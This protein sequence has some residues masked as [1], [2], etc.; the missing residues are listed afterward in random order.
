MAYSDFTSRDL[1]QKFGIR[2][3]ATELFADCP[4]LQPS[5]WLLEALNR[6]QELGFGSEK[7]RSERLVSPILLEL[8]NLNK[9]TFSIYS[10]MNLDV[11]EVAGLRGECDFIFSLSRIQDFVTAPIFCITEAKKQDLE[12][13]T[14]QASAQ[15]LGARKLNDLE[16]NRF[17]TLYG[18][19]TTGIEWRFLQL[20]GSAITIDERRY[21]ITDLPELLG[22]LQCI[23]DQAKGEALPIF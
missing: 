13:G 7:S 2:F 20:T 4:P 6:G 17:E 9:H 19:S 10:G 11:D 21:L 16:G 22:V 3:K 8:S 23:V 12:Q 18:C 15:L 14:I 1:M 5:E